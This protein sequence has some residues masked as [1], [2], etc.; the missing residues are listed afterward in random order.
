[1]TAR[2]TEIPFDNIFRAVFAP[3]HTERAHT[4]THTSKR[5]FVLSTEYKWLKAQLQFASRRSFT[6]ELT[7]S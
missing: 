1:M 5:L 3:S 2:I 4:H 6:S 7:H